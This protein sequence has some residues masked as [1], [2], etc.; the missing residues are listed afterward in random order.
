MKTKFKKEKLSFSKSFL[1]KQQQKS[2]F[3]NSLNKTET[4]WLK[5]R[6]QTL[7]QVDTTQWMKTQQKEMCLKMLLT[8]KS[9][10]ESFGNK[11]Q[12]YQKDK[13]QESINQQLSWNKEVDG[14]KKRF[15][16]ANKKSPKARLTQ[17]L[18]SIFLPWWNRAAKIPS[19]KSC[20]L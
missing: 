14:H 3:K 2:L 13:F 15:C 20:V 6:Q 9:S 12:K 7:L 17:R 5:N 4:L 8:I 11:D 10:N 1:Q 19:K 16:Q 18:N